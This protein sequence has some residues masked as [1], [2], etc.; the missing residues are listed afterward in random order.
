[1]G[2]RIFHRHLPNADR[3]SV[4]AAIIILVYALARFIDLPSRE[5]A[6]QLP[7]VYINL[8]LDENT[9]VALFV[10]GLTASG[11]DWLLR[12]H[13]VLQ[14]RSSVQ[15]IILPALTA[16]AIGLP[17]NRLPFGAVWWVG[18][19][20]GA[21]TLVLVL[22][23]EYIALDTEDLRQPLAAA[24]LSA[25]SFTLFLVLMVAVRDAGVRLFIVL[26][27]VSIATW[28]VSL[29]VMQLRLHGIWTVYEAAIIAFI[30]AQLAAALHYLPL[31]S[32][33]FGLAVLGPTY[34]LTSLMVGLIEGKPAKGILFEP[35]LVWIAT[36][37]AA[38]LV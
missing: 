36:W 27:L 31:S 11:A 21:G 2:E 15:H 22:V 17:L 23:G 13:P 37:G 8:L 38:L 24:G 18:L 1:M 32:V 14:G 10:A 12:D 26:P 19:A 4:L 6:A 25:V 5:F 34:A 3:L 35:I 33:G 9:L 7:G 29:R 28:L 30:L 20:L 16:I